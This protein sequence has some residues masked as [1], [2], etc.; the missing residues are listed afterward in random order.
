MAGLAAMAGLAVGGACVAVVPDLPAAVASAV[1]LAA[2]AA[3]AAAPAGDSSSASAAAET[4]SGSDAAG[5]AVAAAAM[6]ESSFAGSVRGAEATVRAKGQVISCAEARSGK[7]PLVRPVAATTHHRPHRAG[8]TLTFCRAGRGRA[9]RAAGRDYPGRDQHHAWPAAVQGRPDQRVRGQPNHK[10]QGQPSAADLRRWS[11]GH[12][13][14]QAAV[15]VR[16]HLRQGAPHAVFARPPPPTAARVQPT[17]A[18][19]TQVI[20]GGMAAWKAASFPTTATTTAA[21]RTVAE[22][23]A[24]A[25]KVKASAAAVLAE[26]GRRRSAAAMARGRPQMAHLEEVGV[27]Q[28]PDSARQVYSDPGSP[29]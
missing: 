28:A 14:R 29:R 23:K 21:V 6:A 9:G 5:T 27:P 16:V 8:P 13:G 22:Q 7:W 24:A 12:A 1:G 18:G 26:K 4:T 3:A 11:P 20:E 2:A 19:R 15:R 10:V 25:A 17:A